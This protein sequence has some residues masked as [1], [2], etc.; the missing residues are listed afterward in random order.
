MS[1][2]VPM[3]LE[4]LTPTL[5]FP[6]ATSGFQWNVCSPVVYRYLDKSEFVDQ[7]FSNGSLRLASMAKFRAHEDERRLDS[8]EGWAHFMNITEE[9]GGQSIGM[10]TGFGQHGYLLCTSARSD[11][12]IKQKFGGSRI[13]IHDPTQFGIA[14]ARQIPGIVAGYEGACRYVEIR[15]I[16]ADLGYIDLEKMKNERGELNGNQLFNIAFAAMKHWPAFM[17]H[18]SFLAELEYRFLWLTSEP[19]SPHI[20]I[21]VPE[22]IQCCKCIAE[23]ITKCSVRDLLYSRP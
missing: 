22:A 1:I 4:A 11:S 2:K 14:V 7:F 15:V 20:D 3:L 23:P 8:S 16:R 10:W 12:A 5:A 17:K 9:G 21:K 18:V 6:V 13:E 19:V